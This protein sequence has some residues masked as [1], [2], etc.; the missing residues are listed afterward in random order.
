LTQFAIFGL[1][2]LVIIIILEWQRQTKPGCGIPVVLWCEV[3]FIIFFVQELLKLPILCMLRHPG[4]IEKYMIT[5]ILVILVVAI[6]WIIYG[7]TIYFSDENNCQE[8]PATAGFLILMIIL[9]FLGIFI[10]LAF[11]VL[12]CLFCCMCG[13]LANSSS[14][15]EG[16]KELLKKIPGLSMIYDPEK[17]KTVDTCVI[18]CEKFEKDDGKPITQLKCNEMHMFHTEC[19]TENIK[20]GSTKCPIC[21]EE[22][23]SDDIV[24]MNN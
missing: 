15:G 9:L 7:Y 14:E 21:R 6:S 10:M 5:V 17:F 12:L 23:Q 2:Y 11:L 20:A 1:L 8:V 13:M 4:R 22:I 19:I 18:C 3:T 16:N 24:Q